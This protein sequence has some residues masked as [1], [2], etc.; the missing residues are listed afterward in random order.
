MLR[1]DE[2]II[3]VLCG[4]SAS[5]PDWNVSSALFEACIYECWIDIADV[6]R[7]INGGYYCAVVRLH[8]SVSV[9]KYYFREQ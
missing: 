4:W 2:L 3:V 6:L 8:R 1:I 9:I 5:F 7:L